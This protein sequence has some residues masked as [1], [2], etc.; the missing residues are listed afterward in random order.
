M[1]R[2]KLMPHQQYMVDFA[3]NK[4]YFGL[5]ADYG[6]G[7]TLTILSHI[8][9]MGYIKSLIIS[10]KTAILSTWVD[11]ITVHTKFR[12]VILMGAYT[13]KISA[14]N[15]GISLLRVDEGYYHSASLNP[16]IFLI[17]FDGVAPIYD[18]LVYTG[19][20]FCCIDESTK[21]KSPRAKRTKVIWALGKVVKHRAVMTGFPITESLA[22]IYSQIKFLDFG[23]ALGNSYDGFIHDYFVKYYVKIMPKTKKIPELLQKIKPFCLRVTGNII[24]LPPA[25]YKSISIPLTAQ[26]EKLLNEFNDMF[27]LEFGKVKIDTEYI[28]ALLNKSLQICDGFIQDDKGNLEVIET[29]KDESLLDILDE[30]DVSKNKVLIWTA[31]RFSVKKL[32]KLLYKLKYNPITLTGATENVNDVVKSFMNDP[33]RNILI[34]TQ[35]KA[36]A[37]ITLTNCK[38]AIYYSNVWSYDDRANSEA[39]IRRKGSEKHDSIVYTDLITKNSVELK[40]Y[41]CLRKKKNLVDLLKQEFVNA[42]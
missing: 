22:D 5:F 41:E 17:N 18:E 13:Q 39:R 3:K 4:E 15:R 11:E 8:H 19:F 25:V 27:R 42:K 36:A 24:K 1:I 33:K 38:Y 31:F 35:K 14:L 28:F 21:I 9:Q 20:D 29:H 26:Q 37:S 23:K 12:Y 34:A 40:V 10:T 16:V 32:D 30:I 7:K 6:L 2:T